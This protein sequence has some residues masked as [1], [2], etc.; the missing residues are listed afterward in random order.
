VA[1]GED[2]QTCPG[3]LPVTAF[4]AQREA[5]GAATIRTPFP[6]LPPR[7]RPAPRM[8]Y[9]L[10]CTLICLALGTAGRLEARPKSD[11]AAQSRPAPAGRSVPRAK[12]RG[13]SD[14]WLAAGCPGARSL[15]T[16][17]RLR[18][19][20]S[21][22]HRKAAAAQVR[23]SETRVCRPS[24]ASLVVDPGLPAN[25]EGPPQDLAAADRRRA[26]ALVPPERKRSARCQTPVARTKRS[27]GLEG[28]T[29]ARFTRFPD[30][31]FDEQFCSDNLN[32]T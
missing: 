14:C 10:R 24:A 27:R 16:A 3:A 8:N 1:Q 31:C 9:A 19:A 22:A 5:D 13:R 11:A 2:R 15:A 18:R 30:K 21:A 26:S 25:A 12:G 20:P 28:T 17:R 32:Q 23:P 7:A 4:A 29:V 6:R